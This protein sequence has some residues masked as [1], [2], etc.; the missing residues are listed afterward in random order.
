MDIVYIY[1][2]NGELLE[3]MSTK[4]FENM[5]C[6]LFSCDRGIRN[7]NI[8]HIIRSYLLKTKST[9]ILG[10]N[11]K[12]WALIDGVIHEHNILEVV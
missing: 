2:S 8:E 5:V 9:N 6:R 7:H 10:Y 3:E 12:L 4:D 1:N 11:D